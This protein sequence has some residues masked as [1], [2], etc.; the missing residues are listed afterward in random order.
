MTSGALAIASR[1]VRFGRYPVDQ[2]SQFFIDRIDPT[3]FTMPDAYDCLSQRSQLG[4]FLS[5]ARYF[6]S[7]YGTNKSEFPEK[8]IGAF[9]KLR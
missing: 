7:V 5:I 1:A 8:P 2:V 6:L 3:G 4:C 9:F